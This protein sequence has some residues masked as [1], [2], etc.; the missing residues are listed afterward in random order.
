MCILRMLRSA[1]GRAFRIGFPVVLSSSKDGVSSWRYYQNEVARGACDYYLGHG[2]APGR[3]HGRGLAELGVT[4]QWLVEERELE[5]LFGRALHPRTGQPLGRAWRVDGV[6]GYD[7]T[8]SAPKSVSAVWALGG[9][10]VRGQVQASHTA[11]IEAALAY[12][13][14]HAALSRRGVDGPEQIGSAGLAVAVF[15]HR[16]SRAGDPQLHS[17]AGAEQGA[18][19]RRRL[20]H[21]GRARDVSPQEIRRRA[22]SGRAARG[23]A[24]PA[25][26]GIQCCDEERAGGDRRGARIAVEVME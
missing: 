19:R 9:D 25:W 7:L 16:T 24:R 6:T 8:F 12:L 14:T 5:A 2:E 21:P 22:I 26:C 15:G 23:N 18:L 13:D 3:W 4:P 10:Q 11:A 20:A 1:H 17:H